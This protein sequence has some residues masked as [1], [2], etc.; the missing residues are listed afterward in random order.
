MFPENLKYLR[1]KILLGSKE[2]RCTLNMKK[3]NHFSESLILSEM[4][5]YWKTN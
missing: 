4:E 1:L 3:K 5:D 2:R